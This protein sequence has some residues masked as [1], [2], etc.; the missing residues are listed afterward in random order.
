MNKQMLHTKTTT[1]VSVITLTLLLPHGL[2]AQELE[3][4]SFSSEIEQFKLAKI[5]FLPDCSADIS[6]IGIDINIESKYCEKA[7]YYRTCPPQQASTGETCDRDPTYTKCSKAAW[8]IEQDFLTTSCT[9][10]Q[11]PTERC[12]NGEAFYKS[13]NTDNQ[14]GCRDTGYT[15]SCPSG[16]KLYTDKRCSWDSSFGK[17]CSPKSCPENSSLTCTG[18]VTGNDGCGYNC[19]AC[20]LSSCPSGYTYTSIPNGYIQ[21]GEPCNHCSGRKYKVKPNPCSGYNT[22]TY[23]PSSGAAT[24]LSGSATKYSSCASCSSSYVY[25]SSN[26]SGKLLG[27]K[28]GTKYTDCISSERAG[29]IYYSQGTPIG[30]VVTPGL[31]V[32]LQE[33]DM[34]WGPYNDTP[35]PNY[36]YSIS[37]DYNGQSNTATEVSAL[38]TSSSHA[39]GYCYNYSAGSKG[40]SSWFLPAFSQ[41]YQVYSNRS[42]INNTISVIGGTRLGGKGYWSSSEGVVNI[43]EKYRAWNVYFVN[44]DYYDLSKELTQTNGEKWNYAT[45]ST[46]CT[47]SY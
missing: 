30:V 27:S 40:R 19:Y 35:A 5:C 38:G 37:S 7:G 18:A 32:A 26:C 4:K 24:C 23:G 47:F 20:C 34:S 14:Q 39:P 9:I 8:C 41:L 2:K 6:D 46:R 36:N 29:G 1:A 28:C 33:K 11:Y 21:D 12:P 10:P 43:N 42:A 44:G 16:Q 3:L 31:V 22:C 25:D 13:C 45:L 17:C 15:N